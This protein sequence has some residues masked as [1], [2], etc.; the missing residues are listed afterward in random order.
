MQF[1]HLKNEKSAAFFWK[2]SQNTF[3]H[4]LLRPKK[5]ILRKFLIIMSVVNVVSEGAF[6]GDDRELHLV[7][8][9]KHLFNLIYQL[10]I[11]I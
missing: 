4:V 8:L 3:K 1:T 10:D 9:N 5:L 2:N 7:F 6:L 11:V